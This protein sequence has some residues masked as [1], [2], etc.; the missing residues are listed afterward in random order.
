M[1]LNSKKFNI[2]EKKQIKKAQYQN[3]IS[4]WD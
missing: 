1:K 3:I 4:E 2:A